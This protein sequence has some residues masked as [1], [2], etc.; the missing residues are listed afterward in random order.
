MNLDFQCDN[1]D[2]GSLYDKMCMT[3]L[4]LCSKIF[5][6]A[7][8]N[9]IKD[10]ENFFN[11]LDILE[12]QNSLLTLNAIDFGS[13]FERELSNC[14]LVSDEILTLKENCLQYF[15]K[16]LF[17]MVNRLPENLYIFKQ[18]KYFSIQKC[19][20]TI[21]QPKFTVI[22]EIL[23]KFMDTN[24]SA[25]VYEIQWNK[26]PF[27]NW[28]DYFENDIPLN[29]MQFWPKVYSFQDAAGTTHYKELARAVLNMLSIPTSNACV[30]RV[31]S[32]MNFTK[33]KLRNSIQ[34]ELLEALLRIH[35]H[36]NINKICCQEFKTTNYMLNNFNS[37]VMYS[38]KQS[39]AQDGDSEV[40][41]LIAL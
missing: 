28:N 21:T 23:L 18:Y 36:L 11:I 39:D 3:V 1:I 22:K 8:V 26:L 10:L 20:N 40:Y 35:V 37:N 31:F 30:E 25:D 16:L 12:D 24:I 7:V 13:E 27:T 6:P 14:S 19:I 29:L 2:A 34:Y 17:E 5:K 38:S 15:K 32:V 4:A 33:S 9:Q 41:E